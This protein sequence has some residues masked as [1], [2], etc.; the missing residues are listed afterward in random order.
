MR[1]VDDDQYDANGG[2]APGFSSMRN[3]LPD[4]DAIEQSVMKQLSVL[5]AWANLGNDDDFVDDW[6]LDAEDKYL[7][8]EGDGGSTSGHEIEVDGFL[9]HQ[10]QYKQSIVTKK[11]QLYE[12]Q[13]QNRNKQIEKLQQM[14][15]EARDRIAKLQ[16][17]LNASR[18]E[19]SAAQ[20]EWEDE[21][22]M[23][24][25]FRGGNGG[26]GGM[27]LVDL[28]QSGFGA[29]NGDRLKELELQK[30]RE[31]RRQMLNGAAD[32]QEQLDGDIDLS[33]V[34]T[35]GGRFSATLKKMRAFARRRLYPFD[36]DVRQ[37]EARFGYSV[38]SYFKFFRWI[39][40]SFIVISMPCLVLLIL[41]ALYMTTQ[42]LMMLMEAIL[43]LFTAQKWI[44]EDQLSKTVEAVDHDDKQR[45]TEPRHSTAPYQ[46]GL[47]FVKQRY[48]LYARRVLDLCDYPGIE[49]IAVKAAFLAPYVSTLIPAVVTL[50]NSILPTV[51]SLLTK[52]EKW[53]DVGFSIKAMVTRLYL[54]KILNVMI[55]LFSYALLLNPYLLTST[56]SVTGLVTFDGSKVRKNVMMQFKPTEYDCRAEQVA[57]GLLALVVTDFTLSKVMSTA[58]PVVGALVKYL[59]LIWHKFQERRKQRKKTKTSTVVVP[60]NGN[61]P[62]RRTEQ[63]GAEDASSDQSPASVLTDAT[64]PDRGTT[65]N[66]DEHAAGKPK[67][68]GKMAVGIQVTRSEF[69][70]PQKMVALLYSCT[71]ALLATPLAPTTAILALGLHIANFKYDKLLTILPV[72]A[73]WHFQ[74]KPLSPWSAKDAGHFFIKFYF[75]TIVIFISWTHYFLLNRHFPKQRALQDTLLASISDALCVDGT[76]NNVTE[77]CAIN[78]THPSQRHSVGAGRRTAA[79]AV[80]LAQFAQNPHSY[81]AKYANKHLVRKLVANILIAVDTIAFHG[82]ALGIFIISGEI[83]RVL[84]SS[85]EHGGASGSIGALG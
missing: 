15:L 45:Y 48:Q 39:I 74:K 3:S 61:G 14:Q 11:L 12:K 63:V 44:A 62:N 49:L 4:L 64:L 67:S 66:V 58:S 51:I 52:L 68:S 34:V 17:E 47:T 19:F 78:V 26:G 84:V 6:A 20:E 73:S 80:L 28:N 27:T 10:P 60:L 38:A 16:S 72:F 79:C 23:I 75:C 59:A 55:Q 65:T 9:S 21:K 82:A 22:A 77:I 7:N 5:D 40:M 29:R 32:A 46:I 70:V 30:Q 8:N 25:R 50:I 54:A 71:I 42:A 18:E 24:L 81:R 33:G 69:L 85:G 1:M 31:T 36:T 76:F 35:S 13:L 41:H 37:I 56:Q 53:D 83:V 2:D 43:L 57:S